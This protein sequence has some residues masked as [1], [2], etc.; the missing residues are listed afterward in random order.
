MPAIKLDRMAIEE[1]GP[2]PRRMAEAIHGQLGALNGAIPVRE[3]AQALDIEE[4]RQ[5][6]PKGFE[7]ALVTGPE[8]DVGGI[9][10][11]AS[12]PARRQKFSIG[13]ELGHFL[14]PWH[15]SL[16]ADGGFACR[17]ED[18]WGTW[19]SPSRELQRHLAQER[20]ANRFAIELLA[21]RKCFRPFLAGIP[22]LSVVLRLADQLDLSKEA[23][24]RRYVELHEQPTALVYS[25]NCLVR[26]VERT[27]E[28][29][30]VNCRPKDRLPPVPPSEGH[31]GLSAHV[32]AD[33]RD[34]LA[35]PRHNSLVVQ[36]LSQ[37]AGYAIT[38][39]ALDLSQADDDGEI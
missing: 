12:S 39:L 33:P 24:A 7:A 29:P 22:D 8:R 27:D 21:P 31:D 26:Y 35:R 13:H 32:E 9:L 18:I 23:C 30:F 14:N 10:V 36:T 16:D 3:I 37:S 28:F 6:S 1:A 38:L 17:V 2:N 34:W 11:N 20:E 5:V 25:Q 4:I 15:R 19:R